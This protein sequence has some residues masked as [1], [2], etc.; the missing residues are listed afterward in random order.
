MK[1]K[2]LSVLLTLVMVF[3]IIPTA[4]YAASV[5][6]SNYQ[7]KH[8]YDDAVI[9]CSESGLLP[10]ELQ[11]SSL[12][13]EPV[14]W[15]ILSQVLSDVTTNYSEDLYISGTSSCA[16]V[17]WAK[18]FSIMETSLADDDIVTRLDVAVALSSFF[19][20]SNADVLPPLSASSFSDFSSI[21]DNCKS[22]V[23]FVKANSLMNGYGDRTFGGN[24]SLSICQLAQILYNGRDI[25]SDVVMNKLFSLDESQINYV[26]LQNGNTGHKEIITEQAKLSTI[27]QLLNSFEIDS[28]Q[29]A[30]SDGWSYRMKLYF[31]SG[32]ETD[33]YLSSNSVTLNNVKYIS[34]IQHF[35]PIL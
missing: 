6:E 14:T 10:D 35:S 34:A 33:F 7:T 31:S 25:F 30:E 9:Y 2:F 26:E 1:K 24:D 27:I 17:N 32:K 21:P 3:S 12:L 4:A 5:D 19:S 22:S 28:T 15:S 8:W 23:L 11:S 16:P 18:S 20:K 13:Q 29:L